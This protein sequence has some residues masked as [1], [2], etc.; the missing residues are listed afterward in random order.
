MEELEQMHICSVS[1][2]ASPAEQVETVDNDLSGAGEEGMDTG[3]KK[4]TKSQ[5]REIQKKWSS[6]RSKKAKAKKL[7]KRKAHSRW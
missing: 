4:L 6:S 7:K 1:S 2:A 3:K 5:L